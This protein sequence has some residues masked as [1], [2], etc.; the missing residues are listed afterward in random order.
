MSL[1]KAIQV[2][3]PG[4]DFQ[5]VDKEI[6]EPKENEI[7]IKVEACGICRG[8]AVVKEGRFPGIKYPRVPGHAL[9]P[10]AGKRR[11]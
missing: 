7:L 4:G 6:P 9:Y 8:D 5:L 10:E 3:A 1:M 2:N 11:N